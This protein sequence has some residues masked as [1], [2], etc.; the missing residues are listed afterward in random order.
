MDY[1][2][3]NYHCL[4]SESRVVGPDLGNLYTL[5]EVVV[6]VVRPLP[7]YF[8]SFFP[9]EHNTSQTIIA[10]CQR[11]PPKKGNKH[12]TIEVGNEC[13]IEGGGDGLGHRGYEH[14]HRHTCM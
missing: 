7:L 11:P 9:K 1:I 6:V 5:E 2:V 12:V 14:G 13:E 8:P 4:L 3:I 10:I